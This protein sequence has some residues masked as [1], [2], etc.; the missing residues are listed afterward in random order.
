MA[1]SLNHS[2]HG[3]YQHK[4]EKIGIEGDFITSPEI[5]QIFGEMIGVWCYFVWESLGKPNKINL[6]ELGPGKGTLMKDLLHV[7]EKFGG[8]KSCLNVHMIELSQTMRRYQHAALVDGLESPTHNE[9]IIVDGEKLTE[10]TGV[11]VQWHS[12]LQQIPVDDTPIIFVGSMIFHIYFF[13]FNFSRQDKN[14]W[15]L[16]QS[17][18]FPTQIAGGERNWWTLITL[19]THRITF[20]LSCH[21]QPLPR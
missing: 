18:S 7:C 2:P 4:L 1:Q 9:L 21:Q 12:F 8:F 11:P 5:S 15:T 14:F 16:S 19:Q 10:S 3:Y 6:V 20:E 17:I 13:I